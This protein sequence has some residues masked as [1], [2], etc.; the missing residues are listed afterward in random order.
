[1]VR[2]GFIVGIIER[3]F[4]K[5]QVDIMVVEMTVRP[6]AQCHQGKWCIQS[7]ATT[8][9]FKR[10]WKWCEKLYYIL[11]RSYVRVNHE[12]R[13]STTE[14]GDPSWRTRKSPFVT[15]TLRY[16]GNWQ[17][18]QRRCFCITVCRTR[19][20]VFELSKQK[21]CQRFI[22]RNLTPK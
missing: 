14:R 5:M 2:A 12:T 4:G 3:T 20:H 9:I 22:C 13:Q 19:G 1:M 10:H 21:D 7:F 8:S 11:R 15:P 18:P 16:I 17:V 6:R